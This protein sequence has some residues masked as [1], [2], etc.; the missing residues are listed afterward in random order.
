MASWSSHDDGRG[1][2]LL[3]RLR[4]APPCAPPGLMFLTRLPVPAWVDHHPAYL[5]RAMMWFPL[6][7]AAACSPLKRAPPGSAAT[8]SGGLHP[9]ASGHAR[10]VL[11]SARSR[12]QPDVKPSR[13]RGI[14]PPPNAGA[15]VG[16]WGAAWHGAAALLWP[17]PP[18]LAAA[19]S[20]LSTVWLT[21]EAMAACN[22]PEIWKCGVQPVG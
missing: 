3:P 10:I 12:G 14:S 6:I 11:R 13:R 19:L 20:T 7:G 9:A 4:P 17:S 22:R 21:G 1:I 15:A 2:T 18:M 8:G 5:M 16:A